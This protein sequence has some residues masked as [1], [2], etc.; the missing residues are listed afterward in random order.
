[1]HRLSCLSSIILVLLHLSFPPS[2]G[3]VTSE[4]VADQKPSLPF[5]FPSA[6]LQGGPRRESGFWILLRDIF[7]RSAFGLPNAY[8]RRGKDILRSTDSKQSSRTG[9]PPNL[10][11]RYGGDLVL[12]FKINSVDEAKALAEASNILFLDVWESRED[13]VD[14]RIAKDVVRSLLYGCH[15]GYHEKLT[16]MTREGPRL[17]GIVTS[18]DATLTQ[19]GDSRSSSSRLQ[20]LSVARMRRVL[21]STRSRALDFRTRTYIWPFGGELVLPRLPAS[22]GNRTVDA[23]ARISLSSSCPND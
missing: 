8:D 12:R 18:I 7:V 20:L 15:W 10:L 2:L 3:F 22:V 16:L 1:M 6:A 21:N 19:A 14:I 13:W 23:P 5:Q 17:V 11:A 4:P 9:P